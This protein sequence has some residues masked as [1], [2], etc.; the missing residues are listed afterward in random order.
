VKFGV[1]LSPMSEPARGRRHMRERRLGVVL[2]LSAALARLAPP[3]SAQTG[4]PIYDP[5]P[6]NRS[7]PASASSWR[8]SRSSRDLSRRRRPPTSGWCA[9]TAST[10]SGRSPTGRAGCTCPTSTAAVPDRERGVAGVPRRRR[11]VRPG[12]LLGTGARSGVR[13]RDLPPRVPAERQVVHRPHRAGLARDTASR[14]DAT[15]EHR[16]PRHRDRMDRGRS[17]REHLQRNPSRGGSVRVCNPDPRDPADRLQPRGQAA[18]R[19][20]RAAVCR[21]RRRGPRG[22]DR[23]HPGRDHQ[24]RRDHLF[25]HRPTPSSI[26]PTCRRTTRSIPTTGSSS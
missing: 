18:R 6:S 16:L 2:I 24:P 5:I 26:P 15:G 19:G 9:G 11:R 20:L 14:P 12:L 3:A 4:Q 1:F 10:A 25:G 8:S 23:R 7:R 17:V 22:G 21:G 13:L